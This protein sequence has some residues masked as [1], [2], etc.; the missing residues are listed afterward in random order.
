MHIKKFNNLEP[1]NEATTESYKYKNEPNPIID[2]SKNWI[3]NNPNLART[4]PEDADFFKI[5]VFGYNHKKVADDLY[6]SLKES[7]FLDKYPLF[8]IK[9]SPMQ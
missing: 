5:E 4:K 9:I 3:I 1:L 7:G 8:S 6:E 2:K